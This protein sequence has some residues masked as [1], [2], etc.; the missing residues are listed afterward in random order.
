MDLQKVEFD[1]GEACATSLA[2][3]TVDDV[4]RPPFYQKSPAFVIK[5]TNINKPSATAAGTTICLFLR[6]TCPSLRNVCGGADTCVASLFNDWAANS[7]R[8][9][10]IVSYIPEPIIPVILSR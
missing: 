10:P 2:Y 3:T 5:I 7:V 6:D 1:A 8:C 4:K 9:C